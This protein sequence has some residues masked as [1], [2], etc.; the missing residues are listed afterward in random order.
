MIGQKDRVFLQHAS[1]S[2]EELVPEDNFYR[3]L[4]ECINLEFIRDLV[5]DLYSN[6]GRPSIDP[7]V[8]FKLQLIAFF[9]G[10]RSERQLMEMVKSALEKIKDEDEDIENIIDQNRSIGVEYRGNFQI[11]VVPAI[12][13]EKDKLYRI[14]DKRTRQPVDSNPK[15]HGKNL[16][17]AN[18]NSESG[19]V[20]RLV[21]I[22]KLLKSWKR[23]KC[24]YVKSFH[25]ELLAVEILRDEPIESF[26]VGLAKFFSKVG[27][28]LQEAC[29]VDPAN[30]ENHIDVYLDEDGVRDDLLG[31]VAGENDLA[32]NALM[33]EEAGE[34]DGAV[35]EWKKIFESDNGNR[36]IT[37]P[38][39]SSGPTIITTP[40]KQHCDVPFRFDRR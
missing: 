3:Q 12:E 39:K 34:N 24:D 35:D 29:L 25:L 6:I 40:P 8:F 26:S 18:E 36:R 14:F 30:S 20:R 11:D 7:I 31:L 2:L 33:L 21:P 37:A 23:D 15:L 32:E 1:I 9:E 27:D 17:E 10:I 4:E 19:S 38:P 13:I 16:S 28:Y 5:Q 22:I